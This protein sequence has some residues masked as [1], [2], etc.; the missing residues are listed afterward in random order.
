ML[1]RSR[2]RD[3]NSRSTVPSRRSFFHQAARKVC[4]RSFPSS[5]MRPM[6]PEMRCQLFGLARELLRAAL[7][8]WNR[9]CALRLFSDVPHC[10]AIQPCCCSA[11][12]RGIDRAFIELQHVLAHLLEAASHTE[13]V[14]RPERLQRLQ[15]HEIERPLQD[16][17]SCRLRVSFGHCI[18]DDDLTTSC[19]PVSVCRARWWSPPSA[20]CP[21][22]SRPGWTP[23]AGRPSPA[24]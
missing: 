15:D 2:R 17:R 20:C 4:R 14:Q 16:L 10:A 8:V 13:P 9:T 12:Q 24:W 23:S 19:K 1:R 7:L 11:Q 3:P 5:R 21:R 22:R 18:E 6:T